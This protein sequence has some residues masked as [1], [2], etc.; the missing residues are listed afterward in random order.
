MCRDSDT[1]WYWW[2]SNIYRRHTILGMGEDAGA[3]GFGN[4]RG[5]TFMD[6]GDKER[7]AD[8]YRQTIG[9]GESIIAALQRL[10]SE[11][12]YIREDCVDWLARR[13]GIPVA[14]FYGVI[15]FCS[16]FYQ[17]PRGKHIITVCSGTVCHVKGA[18]RIIDRLRRDLQLADDSRTTRD[19]RFTVEQVN[20][21]GACSIAPV[22]IVDEQVFGKQHPEAMA[23][24]V[25][26][27]QKAG[28]NE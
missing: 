3:D 17:A 1:M 21:V 19:M 2:Y 4:S 15:T 10:Q 22:V 25:K 26:Q 5:E 6:A 18:A 11:F 16:Q 20:C 8:I 14:K 23:R 7:L 28:Q 24:V 13:A 12:G 27:Y 9:T